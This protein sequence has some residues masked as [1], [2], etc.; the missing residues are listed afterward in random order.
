MVV[1]FLGGSSWA[2]TYTGCAPIFLHSVKC[3]GNEW[4]I[5]D[6][7]LDSDTSEDTH[8]NDVGVLC[9]NKCECIRVAT[10]RAMVH[11]RSVGNS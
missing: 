5:E 4:S 7:V 10:V 11:Y 3:I 9:F 2:N 8:D 1:C 6:C